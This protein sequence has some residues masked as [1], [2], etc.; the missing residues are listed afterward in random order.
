MG[1]GHMAPDII[2]MW[3]KTNYVKTSNLSCSTFVKWEGLGA[4][5]LHWVVLRIKW[6]DTCELL[7]KWIANV[8]C[9]YFATYWRHYYFIN[10][11]LLLLEQVK[12]HFNDYF[13]HSVEGTHFALNSSRQSSP[14]RVGGI[15]FWFR[16][17]D[18]IHS[19]S[20]WSCLIS[21]VWRIVY[22]F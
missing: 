14:F 16:L 2:D 7:A 21:L 17:L 12:E 8:T 10:P 5:C 4:V 19:S 3:P 1:F 20:S 18:W 22:D 9:W 6:E 13:E 15:G 11:S